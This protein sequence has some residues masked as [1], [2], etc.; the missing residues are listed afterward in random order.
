VP[1]Y[2]AKEKYMA[3]KI[4]VGNLNYS[5]T[6][7]TLQSAFAQFGEVTSAV[8]IKDRY[9]DQSKGFGFIEMADNDAANAAITSLNGKEIDSRQVRVNIAEDKPRPSRPRS[10]G[11]YGGNRDG[12]GGYNN[13]YRY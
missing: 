2:P 9:T 7:E 10:G 1:G 6:E 8:V 3:Q 4:Y 13:N 11:G 12:G 5:T